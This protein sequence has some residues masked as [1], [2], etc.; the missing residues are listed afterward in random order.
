MQYLPT[1][2]LTNRAIHEAV[3]TGQIKLLSG[4]WIKVN[5]DSKPSRFVT[6]RGNGASIWAVHPEGKRGVTLPRFKALHFAAF[7]KAA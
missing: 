6:V 7:G 3:R 4:Q 5:R 1:V 2:D